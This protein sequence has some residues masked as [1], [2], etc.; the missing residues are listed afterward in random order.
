MHITLIGLSQVYPG[1]RMRIDNVRLGF[2]SNSSSTHSIILAGSATGEPEGDSFGWGKFLQCTPEDKALYLAQT[3]KV[4]ASKQL[5]DFAVNELIKSLFGEYFTELSDDGYVD[6]QSLISI[7]NT[8][9]N[10]LCVQFF[11]E[12]ANA[13]ITDETV[14][15]QGGNDNDTY[16]RGELHSDWY[17]LR[18]LVD[19]STSHIVCRKDGTTWTVFNKD[20]GTKFRVDFTRDGNEA[21]LNFK[22]EYPEL[23]DLK[24]T[25]YC[26]SGCEFCYQNSSK[27]GKHAPFST[28]EN[29]ILSLEDKPPFEIALGGGEPT[30]HPDFVN[31][32]ELCHEKNIV[33]NFTTKSN[34]WFSDAKI[35][36]AVVK[37]VGGYAKSVTNEYEICKEIERYKILNTLYGYQQI[38]KL[39][40]HYI[41]DAHPLDNLSK[42]LPNLGYN[43]LILLGYKEQGRAK[44]RP[45]TNNG[46]LS[47]VD[48]NQRIGVDTLL[49]KQYESEM[50]EKNINDR[51][52]YLEEGKHSLY[53]D[54]VTKTYGKSSYCDEYKPFSSVYMMLN[55]F[56]TW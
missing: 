17:F 45:Y 54:A 30:S 10:K 39:N 56:K 48:N 31:I 3:F 9:Q 44:T 41:L 46:W 50:K 7:P 51:L 35:R 28:I 24:I 16:E 33:V 38:P 27:D 20:N 49:A 40:F 43:P 14:H 18:R 52:Y 12:M 34:D 22:S 21:N 11:A 8:L 37:Y 29:I 6:H 47:L 13:L 42:I 4:S 1:D 32:L 15:I 5:E 53:I 36:D 25:D 23:I 2:A 55:D 19:K 26:E